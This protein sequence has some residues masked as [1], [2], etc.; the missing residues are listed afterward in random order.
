MQKFESLDVEVREDFGKGSARRARRDGQIPAVVYGHGSEPEHLLLP[1]HQ[2]TL[3]V[4]QPN[5]I[6]S[7]KV[8]GDERLVMVKDIQRHPLRQTVDH[9]DLLIVKRGEKVSVDVF[10]DYQ[11]EVAPG[12]AATLDIQ[13]VTVLAEALNIPDT[14]VVNIDG[15]EEG[16]VLASEIELPEGV[17]LEIEEDTV[18]ATIAEPQEVEL[19][20]DEEAEEGEEAAEAPAEEKSEEDS[21]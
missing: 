21:E 9:L 15:R 10:L 3:A 8:A 6:L 12:L 7:L 1:S 4:R 18:I 16:S 13:E 20:E 19:P 2:T 17:E 5:A 14:L 11:G